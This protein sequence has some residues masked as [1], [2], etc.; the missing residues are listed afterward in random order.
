MKRYAKKLYGSSA[1]RYIAVG[2]ATVALDIVGLWFLHGLVGVNVL[3]SAT[4]S[5]WLAIVFNFSMNRN[6]TF[7]TD[8]VK[9]TFR[10]AAQ[11][12]LLLGC[13]YIFT[14]VFI[15]FSTNYGLHFLAAK[16]TAVIIQ[17]SWTYFAYKKI[18]FSS[19]QQL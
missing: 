19:G 9:K 17:V 6:W 11:Y 4:I 8:P 7:E 3:T 1:L 2:G 12:L 14:I 5:Y 15:N 10:Q 13:N 18:I 16:A